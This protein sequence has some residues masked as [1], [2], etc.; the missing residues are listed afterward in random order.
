M[1]IP[2]FCTPFDLRQFYFSETIGL[3]LVVDD[4]DKNLKEFNFDNFILHQSQSK[5]IMDDF[6]YEILK[7]IEK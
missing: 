5:N 7:I 4:K 3:P 6:V 1:G 2:S